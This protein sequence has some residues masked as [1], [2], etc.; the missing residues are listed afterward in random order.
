MDIATSL[1]RLQTLRDRLREKFVDLRL[2]DY[3]AKFEDIATAAEGIE[4]KGN[5][6]V[7]IDGLTTDEVELDKGYYKKISVSFDGQIYNRL[8]MI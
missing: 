1:E 3:S 8:R 2:V 7:T 4:Y 6:S 5:E